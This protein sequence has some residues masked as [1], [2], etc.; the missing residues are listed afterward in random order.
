MLFLSKPLELEWGK[1]MHVK[2]GRTILT[3]KAKKKW[4]WAGTGSG[5]EEE[6]EMGRVSSPRINGASDHRLSS[7][8]SAARGSGFD[9]SRSSTI[10][11]P[12]AELVA[13]YS[14]QLPRTYTAP[15]VLSSRLN[16]SVLSNSLHSRPSRQRSLSSTGPVMRGERADALSA[17]H[18]DELEPDESDTFATQDVRDPEL[19]AASS[20]SFRDFAAENASP[21]L[22]SQLAGEGSVG[23]DAYGPTRELPVQRRGLYDL[24]DSLS[25]RGASPIVSTLSPAP[26]QE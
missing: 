3:M 19:L 13:P 26:R 20:M 4:K 10:N 8:N 5:D 1:P 16:R 11:D 17:F 9:M 22:T 14:G 12:S 18:I 25:E 2:I 23:T 21:S 24:V 6:E 15:N 7:P